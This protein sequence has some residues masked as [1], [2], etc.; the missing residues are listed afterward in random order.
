MDHGRI[1]IM[2]DMVRRIN[3]WCNSRDRAS[4][5]GNHR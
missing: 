4:V 5:V 2:A 3:H 1:N